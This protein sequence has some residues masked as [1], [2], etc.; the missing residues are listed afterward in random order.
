[1]ENSPI[2]SWRRKLPGPGY[3]PKTYGSTSYKSWPGREDLL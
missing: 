3:Q 2:A 1:M